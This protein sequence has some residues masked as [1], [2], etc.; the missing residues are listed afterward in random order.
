M[1]RPMALTMG[2]S[3]PGEW[4]EAMLL[5]M[6]PTLK[7]ALQASRASTMAGRRCPDSRGRT[8]RPGT[9]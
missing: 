5:V 7:T 8:S 6:Q 4:L 2:V 9:G 3:E 1:T